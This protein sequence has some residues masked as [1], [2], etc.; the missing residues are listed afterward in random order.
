MHP[1]ITHAFEH[2]VR[3]CVR[4]HAKSYRQSQPESPSLNDLKQMQSIIRC[5]LASGLVFESLPLFAKLI[6][7]S[8]E[9]TKGPATEQ[10][11]ATSGFMASVD[12]D[13]V[14]ATTAIQKALMVPSGVRELTSDEGLALKGLYDVLLDAR[15]KHS[16]L[17]QDHVYE[18]GMGATAEVLGIVEVPV[19]NVHRAHNDTVK[20]QNSTPPVPQETFSLGNYTLPRIFSGLWQMSSPS[21]GSAP[22][23]D[24]MQQFS[25]HVKSGFTAFDMADH[26]GDAELIFGR[27][28]SQYPHKQFLFAGTKLCVFH[29]MPT[30][31]REA[32]AANV[33]E[34]C[35]RLQQP[36][37]DLLQFHWQHYEDSSYLDALQYL[38]SDSRVGMIGL[39]NFD[40]V[41]LK[42]VLEAGI[43][44][45]SNQVQFSLIDSRPVEEMAAV[46]AQHDVK[47]LTYGTLC[48]GF[49]S[50]KWL[51]Q[52]E[53]DLY[54]SSNNITPS[55]RKYYSMICNWGG[56][57][58]LQ[59][60]LQTLRDI[61][62]KHSVPG[63][64]NVAT[65]WVLDHD[66]V[67]AVIVGARMGISDH[68]D[69]N[70]ATF[71]WHLDGQ[72][73]EAIESV[74]MK[75]RRKE[76]FELLGDCGAEYR[77]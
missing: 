73:H 60:L 6:A 67:G 42:R 27:F 7:E 71:G 56:W 29:R 28:R 23:S 34:R 72:D 19:N 46:C 50:E 25:K 63:I 57:D 4:G 45:H 9:W 30:V 5:M 18:R 24:I 20:K 44:V 55:Q 32:M 61:A 31:S 11:N 37:L 2:Q 77:L 38:A 26:Y 68:S 15:G 33:S 76:V 54:S 75:S 3:E 64:S 53:P 10:H 49:L 51:G 35:R 1:Q 59:E 21:W 47:L 48:G 52:P 12:G 43:T 17:P 69:A 8:A 16:S 65:R 14:Q 13:L 36:K 66:Y 39:C 40:T 22:S 41:N 70:L 58:L 62:T 74:L